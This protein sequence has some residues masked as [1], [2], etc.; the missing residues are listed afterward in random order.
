MRY[1]SSYAD[2]GVRDAEITA[3]AAF[4]KRLF[5]HDVVPEAQAAADSA[6]LNGPRSTALL[7]V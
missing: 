4:G 1:D 7:T 5:D 2:P 3:H 6:D